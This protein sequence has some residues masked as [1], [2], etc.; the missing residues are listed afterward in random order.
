MTE[1][2]SSHLLRALYLHIFAIKALALA[3]ESN[4]PFLP[5]TLHCEH[6]F[7]RYLLYIIPSSHIQPRHASALVFHDDFFSW[8]A[9]VLVSTGIP[10]DLFRGGS[11]YGGDILTLITNSR[12]RMC[13]LHLLSIIAFQAS[14]SCWCR[15]LCSVPVCASYLNP[16]RQK[17]LSKI[18]L[19]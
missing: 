5:I 4:I 13:W 12:Y 9:L 6:S 7:F 10:W 2:F 16:F 14:S 8:M 1:L 11:Y 15:N 3:S 18:N 19:P 17:K